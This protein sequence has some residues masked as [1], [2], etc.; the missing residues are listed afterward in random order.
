MLKNKSLAVKQ[1]IYILSSVCLI[2]IA[3]F[4]YTAWQLW[5]IMV[6]DIE[7]GTTNLCKATAHRLDQTFIDVQRSAKQMAL[8][9]EDKKLSEKDMGQ[10]LLKTIDSI[11]KDRPQVFGGSI[12]FSPYAYDSASKYFMQYAYYD[13]G[14]LKLTRLGG[15]DYPYFFYKWFILPQTLKHPIWTEPYF[16]DGGG[17]ILMTTYSVP[18]FRQVNDKQEFMG[19]ITID[20]SLS[21]L[22][23]LVGATTVNDSGY[24]FL[25]SRFGRF[26]THPDPDKIMNS[27]IF[28]LAEEDHDPELRD[29]GRK[30]ISGQSGFTPYRHSEVYDSNSWLCYTPLESNGWIMAIVFPNE[31]LFATLWNVELKTFCLFIAG[32]IFILIIVVW[33]SHKITSPL[34]KLTEASAI[35]GRGNFHAEIPKVDTGDEIGVLSSA[36]SNMQLELARYIEELKQ[37]TAAKEKMESELKIARDIQLGI[38]PQLL[39]PFPQCEEFSLYAELNSAKAVGGDLYDFFFLD[40]NNMCFVVGDVSGKGIPA[41][42]FMAVTQTLHRSTAGTGMSTGEIVTKVSSALGQNNEMMMFVTYFMGIINLKTGA[43][44]FTNAGHNPPYIIKSG[45]IEK[46]STLHGPPIA[47]SDIIY[48]ASETEL[49]VGDCIVLYTDGVTEAMSCVNEE[50]SDG[51]L[52]EV[53]EKHLTNNTPRVITLD[54]IKDVRKF[55]GSAE[56]S[57]D[58]TVMTIR[59]EKKR[60]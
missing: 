43:L 6:K 10:I 15:D 13:K 28:S 25:L 1:S 26:V 49:D 32:L 38:L 51:R 18:F 60:D 44:Q 55:V 3:V 4:A 33:I 42:L 20:L 57:D 47:I 29:V 59:L 16:D 7:V 27:T 24:A 2:F 5:E 45:K 56:Q 34:R 35:I 50:F 40:E 37:T 41:S 21:W 17:N 52:H 36:F 39:P 31:K 12:A 54:I 30:M 8:Q 11:H 23:K 14:Q 53:L 22:Q 9:F 58:I 48:G 46:L 19:V